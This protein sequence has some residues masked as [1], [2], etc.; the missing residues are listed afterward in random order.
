M[1]DDF[2]ER[3]LDLSFG[4]DPPLARRSF[5]TPAMMNTTATTHQMAVVGRQV[6]AIERKSEDSAAWSG[7]I[8]SLSLPITLE[9]TRKYAP[10]TVKQKPEAWAIS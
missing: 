3:L 7:R 1:I 6:T 5:I 9:V 10:I 2:L 4:D 8:G